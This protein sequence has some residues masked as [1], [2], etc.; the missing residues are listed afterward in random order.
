MMMERFGISAFEGSRIMTRFVA[1]CK[2][3][4]RG[5]EGATMVEYGL[6]VGLIAAICVGVI[7]TIGTNLSS[8]FSNIG[9]SV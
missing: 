8:F 1:A 4:A 3:L 6:M 9:G 2:G 7:A 5:Q